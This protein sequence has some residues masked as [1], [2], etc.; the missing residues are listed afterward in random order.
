[1]GSHIFGSGGSENSGRYGFKDRKI[2][3]SLRLFQDDL[4]ERLYKLDA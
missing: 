3:N 4:V 2:F 1:M